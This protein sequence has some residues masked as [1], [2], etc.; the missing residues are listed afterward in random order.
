MIHVGLCNSVMHWRNSS[1][2]HDSA[3]F[4]IM[5]GSTMYIWAIATVLL[6]VIDVRIPI[7]GKVSYL[8]PASSF[9]A[10]LIIS[11]LTFKRPYNYR[12]TLKRYRE[13]SRISKY[14]INTLSLFYVFF[15]PAFYII[16]ALAVSGK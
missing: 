2:N 7:A 8:L 11:H 3:A 10:A 13:M 14:T 16:F 9:F 4:L 1:T 5:F 12:R 15:S 6:F